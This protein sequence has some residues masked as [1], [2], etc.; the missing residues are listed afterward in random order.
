MRCGSMKSADGGASVRCG[1]S[2]VLPFVCVGP[3]RKPSPVIHWAGSGYVFGRR[4]LLG[5]LS[6]MGNGGILDVV[7]TVVASFS[8]SC[9]CGVAVGLAAF[10]HS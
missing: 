3:R 7:T 4:N 10:G 9:L 8:E 1:G 6:R 2:Y 5:A